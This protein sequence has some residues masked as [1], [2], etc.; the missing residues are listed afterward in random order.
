VPD[1]HRPSADAALTR[2]VAGAQMPDTS[3]VPLH[4]DGAEDAS[5]DVRS[6]A[7]DMH[8]MLTSFNEGVQRGLAESRRGSGENVRG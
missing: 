8:A 5:P 7:T 4:A 3:V 1:Q 2:R 6:A